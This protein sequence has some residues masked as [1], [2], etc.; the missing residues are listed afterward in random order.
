MAMN[1]R[2]AIQQAAETVWSERIKNC[3]RSGKTIKQWCQDNGVTMTSFYTWRKRIE[4]AE[5]ATKKPN[6]KAGGFAKQVSALDAVAPSVENVDVV[7]SLGKASV[8]IRRAA[9]SEMVE[10]LLRLMIG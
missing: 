4:A 1:H 8:T 10:T 5:A 3:E 2:D 6:R 9:D 7:M